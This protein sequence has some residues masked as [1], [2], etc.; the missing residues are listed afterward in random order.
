MLQEKMA[1]KIVIDEKFHSMP[2]LRKIRETNQR[3]IYINI[4]NEREYN[5]EMFSFD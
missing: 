4:D 5:I 1:I 3:V 2:S